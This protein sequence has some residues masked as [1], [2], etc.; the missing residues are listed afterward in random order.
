[1]KAINKTRATKPH[2]QPTGQ[3]RYIRRLRDG[4]YGVI[5]DNGQG[6]SRIVSVHNTEREAGMAVETAREL[7]VLP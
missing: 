5:D 4:R 1:M 7:V 2:E 3:R 6:K